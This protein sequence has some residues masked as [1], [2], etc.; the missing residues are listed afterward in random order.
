MKALS[1]RRISRSR[2]VA[3]HGQ[4]NPYTAFT[5]DR[6]RLWALMSRDVRFVLCIL[7]VVIGG[8]GGTPMLLSFLGRLGRL[9]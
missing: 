7:V 8:W 4:H 5:N 9:F 3:E 2:K 6:E 1:N